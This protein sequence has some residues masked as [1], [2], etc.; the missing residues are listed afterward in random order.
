MTVAEVGGVERGERGRV[1][2]LHERPLDPREIARA[3]L[4]DERRELRAEIAE[5]ERARRMRHQVRTRQRLERLRAEQVRDRAEVLAQGVDVPQEELLAV[6]LHLRGAR[7]PRVAG[8]Q[9]PLL[10]RQ[11]AHGITCAS[12]AARSARARWAS[13]ASTSQLGMASS[14]STS[15]ETDPQR[16]RERR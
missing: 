8:R 3:R 16:A 5:R 4:A 9:R 12:T 6:D 10:G 7:E 14:H 11:R 1:E 2:R 15:V 13:A